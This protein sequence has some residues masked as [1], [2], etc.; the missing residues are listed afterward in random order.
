M[1]LMGAL[2]IG[3]SS[4]AA[5]QAALQVTGNNI[6]NAG[7]AGYTRQTIELTP[8]GTQSASDIPEFFKSFFDQTSGAQSRLWVILLFQARSPGLP[9][10]NRPNRVP[11]LAICRCPASR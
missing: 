7:T 6:A 11:F 2:E 9:S 10:G 3:K 1:S 4:L 5:Q 8:A